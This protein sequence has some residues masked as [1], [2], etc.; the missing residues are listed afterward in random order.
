MTRKSLFVCWRQC[1]VDSCHIRTLYPH[2]AQQGSVFGVCGAQCARHVCLEQHELMRNERQRGPFRRLWITRPGRTGPLH[3]AQKGPKSPRLLVTDARNE[4][5]KS[6]V[7]AEAPGALWKQEFDH[8]ERSPATKLEGK[9]A[10]SLGPVGIRRERAVSLNKRNHR[11]SYVQIGPVSDAVS[12]KE[13]GLAEYKENR[14]S[15]QSRE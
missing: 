12:Q 10:S 7:C 15:C 6:L 5:S 1:A 8:W 14:V 4:L 3:S 9:R 2:L 11:R 13:L